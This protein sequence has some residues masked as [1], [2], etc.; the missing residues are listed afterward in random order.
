VQPSRRRVQLRELRGAGVAPEPPKEPSIEPS[1]APAPAREV[2]ATASTAGGGRSV[3]VFFA[4]LGEDWRL[5]AAQRARLAPAVRAALEA[6][7]MPQA[8]AAFT[9]A[10]ST[11]VCSP[12]AVLAAR[13][14]P[15][16]L[17]PPTGWRP[18]RPPWCGECDERTRMLGFDGDAPRSC[19]RC[20]PRPAR[21]IAAPAEA[22]LLANPAPHPRA[23]PSRAAT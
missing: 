21:S 4:V 17:P 10:N 2:P 22:A 5:T 13:L 16:E 8:L 3:G 1:A 12:Y 20:K 15:A 6:G 18:A 23:S 14:S 19:P 11:G 7:W 9:G